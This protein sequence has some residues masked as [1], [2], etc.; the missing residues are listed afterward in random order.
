[1][2]FDWLSAST[3][4]AHP[5][6]L[7]SI[8]VVLWIYKKFVRRASIAWPRVPTGFISFALLLFIAAPQIERLHNTNL[9]LFVDVVATL[10]LYLGVARATVY[11]LIDY[12]LERRRMVKVPT[13]TSD[14]LLAILW[15]IIIMVIVMARSDRTRPMAKAAIIR[16]GIATI[17]YAPPSFMSLP[18]R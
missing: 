2:N 16:R 17:I 18:T 14:L 6:I 1:M 7:L 4:G 11:L 10:A 12:F 13:I 3:V 9:D 5:L 8:V 15:F